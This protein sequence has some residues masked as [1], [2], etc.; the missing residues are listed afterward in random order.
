MFMKLKFM[1]SV[2]VFA[3]TLTGNAIACPLT[4]VTLSK[5]AVNGLQAG[6]EIK[7]Y[8]RGK[9]IFLDPITQLGE[10]Y[11]TGLTQANGTIHQDFKAKIFCMCSKDTQKRMKALT[12][13]TLTTGAAGGSATL[14]FSHQ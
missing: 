8:F 14:T 2:V 5:Q 11:G 4:K 9:T 1:I 13:M 6:H 3:L 10:K 7:F 12:L